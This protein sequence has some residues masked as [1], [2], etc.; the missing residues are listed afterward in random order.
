L[1]SSL[2]WLCYREGGKVRVVLQ[3]AASLIHAR[4]KAALTDL[5]DGTFAEGHHLDAKMERRVLKA[6]IGRRLSQAQAR[7]LLSQLD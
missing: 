5:G 6:L 1:T 2:F 4:L 3:P 7:K